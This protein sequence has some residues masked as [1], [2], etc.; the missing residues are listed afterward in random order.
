MTS[1]TGKDPD[2][3]FKY[4]RVVFCLVVLSVG[5]RCSGRCGDMPEENPFNP[6]KP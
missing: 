6:H 1:R 5:R 4:A 3:P 2:T